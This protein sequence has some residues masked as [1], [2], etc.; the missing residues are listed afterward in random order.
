MTF[1]PSFQDTTVSLDVRDVG[2]EQALNAL[3]AA[4]RTFHRVVDAKVLNVVPDTAAKRREFEQQ[5]VKTIFLSNADLKETI[6]LLRVVLGAR[7]VAPVPGANALTINDTPDKVAAAERIVAMVDKRKAEVVV[8]VQILEVAR[9]K[10]REYGIYLTSGLD[11]QGIEGIA[12][13][14]F[15]DPTAKTLEDGPYDRGNLVVSSLPGAVIRLLE[16]DSS[17][18]L[19]ANPQLRITESQ[20]AQARFGDQVPVPVTTFTAI[21]GGGLPQQP[22][23]SF[24]YKNVGVNIDITPRVHHDGE[25]TLQL[26]LDISAVGAPGYQGLP[27]FNSRTV[28]STIRLRDGETNLLAGLILDNE[29]RGLT[30]I[31]GLASLPFLGRLFAKNKDENTQ[32]D[33]VMTLTPHV[34]RQTEIREEDLRSFLVGGEISPFLFDVPAQS[35][36]PTPRPAE[37]PRVEPIRPPT[38]TPRARPADVGTDQISAPVMS[39]EIDR[40][41]VEPLD[42]TC[43]ER[44]QTPMAVGSGLDRRRQLLD[45]HLAD[46]V[47]LDVDDR[48]APAFDRDDLAALRH[49]AEA[50][51]HEAGDRR[52]LAGLGQRDL[53]GL[54]QLRGGGGPVHDHGAVAHALDRALLPVVLVLDVADDLLD[55]VLEGH[56]AAHR[57]VLVHHHGHVRAPLLQLLQQLADLLRLRHEVHGV[58]D[59]AD[60][61]GLALL[62]EAQR[63]LDVDDADHVVDRVLVHRE[64]R[65]AALD[66]E[67]ADLGRGRVDVEG[68][69]LGAGHH[70]LA[71]R[72]VGELEHAVDDLHLGLLEDPLLAALLDHV[73]DLLLGDERPRARVPDAEDAQDDAR[74]RGEEGDHPPRGALH[75]AE[76]AGERASAIVS[77]YRSASAFGT[78]SPMTSSR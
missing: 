56:E 53:V 67:R 16:T 51:E 75:G 7:R 76:R 59:L 40:N 72:R 62:E 78:S 44:R 26:K 61:D 36:P 68:E 19:L 41:V 71:D 34:V 77:V 4:G 66:D 27:T 50:L 60:H 30:G 70:H 9:N 15:P 54:A 29:R 3:A 47:A 31:P 37:P 13:G 5:V 48:E 55:Q 8:E 33:I 24:E 57:A 69:D 39:A 73:L 52:E 20:T 22:I 10:L 18:R 21:A 14:I 42:A 38:P 25:V 12:S 65:V 74:G 32:T 63:V 45:L 35:L 6:D 49:R 2:F 64:A 43:R 23:T 46:A 17:T 28:N 11:A 1:D 58:E